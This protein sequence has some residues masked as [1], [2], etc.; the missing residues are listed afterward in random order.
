MKADDPPRRAIPTATLAGAPP[1]A[2]LKADASANDTP[3]TVGTKSMSNSPKH[4]TCG[5]LLVPGVPSL[6][7]TALV[8]TADDVR[9]GARNAALRGRAAAAGREQR[10]MRPAL[11]QGRRE[12]VGSRP[13]V[14]GGGGGGAAWRAIP[15]L[16]MRRW[17]SREYGRRGAAEPIE[18]AEAARW[19]G[20]GGGEAGS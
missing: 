6:F 8:Q 12:V 19:G 4:T 18:E 16:R 17:R 5:E 15:E 13:A 7:E 20:G 14:K 9:S 10:K 1:G 11:K 2:F 3:L